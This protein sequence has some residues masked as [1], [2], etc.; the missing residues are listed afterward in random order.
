M[1]PG[2]IHVCVTRH[3]FG[4]A[5]SCSLLAS[6]IYMYSMF[7]HTQL[8]YSALQPKTFPWCNNDNRSSGRVCCTNLI[9]DLASLYVTQLTSSGTQKSPGVQENIGPPSNFSTVQCCLQPKFEVFTFAL[10]KKL[11]ATISLLYSI[12]DDENSSTLVQY[13]VIWY[14]AS[15][16]TDMLRPLMLMPLINATG[17]PCSTCSCPLWHAPTLAR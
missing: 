11:K 10:H 6:P 4:T 8:T 12:E 13:M 17:D 14:T 2:F 16:S 5:S 15:L 1:Q 9:L 7:Q 3:A